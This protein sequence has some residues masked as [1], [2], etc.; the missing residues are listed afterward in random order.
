MA[1]VRFLHISTIPNACISVS[2]KLTWHSQ[3]HTYQIELQLSA[4]A[5]LVDDVLFIEQRDGPT[6]VAKEAL[7]LEGGGRTHSASWRC[8]LPVSAKGHREHLMLCIMAEGLG[9]CAL[10]VSAKVYETG[11]A[12]HARTGHTLKSV[13][14]HFKPQESGASKLSREQWLSA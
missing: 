9:E 4:G 13:I 1:P 3:G 10:P 6:C 12:K 11:D 2:D 5:T 14:A 7:V 8:D